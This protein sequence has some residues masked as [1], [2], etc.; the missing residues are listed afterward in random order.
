MA[1]KAVSRADS[2]LGTGAAAL[3][4]GGVFDRSAAAFTPRAAQ[5]EMAQ[6]VE[7]TLV[8]GGV[9]VAESG[10]GTGKTYAYL[11]PIIATG[12]RT[13]ISTATLHLQEQIFNRDLPQ[14]RAALGISVDA[15][16][17][18]G[19]ANY[20]CR[21]R[22]ALRMRQS[23]LPGE[24]QPGDYR[25]LERWAAATKHGDIAEVAELG[26]GSP[27]WREVTSTADNCLGGTCP[28]FDGCFVFKARR[29]AMQANLVVV[30]HHLFFSDMAMQA[31]GGGELLP[32]HDAVIFDEA[33]TLAEIAS[34]FFGFAVS[35]AQ[36]AELAADTAAAEADERSGVKL[37]PVTALLEGAVQG[38]QRV[39]WAA[40]ESQASSLG[41]ASVLPGASRA[42]DFEDLSN[43]EFG[44][45]IDHLRHAM[46]QF[47]LTLATAAPAGDGL[48]RCHERCLQMQ[49]HLDAWHDGGDR[50]LIRWAEIGARWFRLHGTPLS[51]GARFVEMMKRS[52]AWV[53][54]SATLA[55]GD[56]FSAF[57]AAL[58]LGEVE[59]RRWSS[60]YDFRRHAL[61]YL[62]PD[63]PDPRDE[64]YADALTEVLAAVLG[65]S[66]GRAF[67]LFT[68]H[69]MMRRVHQ[70]LSASDLD[71]ALLLQ[72]QAPKAE[73]LRRFREAPRAALFGSA[74]FWEGVDVQGEDLSCV[75]IDKLP[76]AAPGEPVLK[77]RL[78][79]CEEAGDNPFMDIQVPAAVTAL[80]QGAGRLIRSET[81][82]G[83]LV[84]CDPRLL[85][86]GYG[87]LFL[88]SLP[89]MTQ[90]RSMDDVIAFFAASP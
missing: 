5:Q 66:R 81:D 43:A 32:K 31:E 67:C 58:G 4:A 21:H 75:I 10:T 12:K 62:P 82:R 44:R 8:H 2:P 30:N 77:N 20:L 7:D 52:P 47:Q 27:V 80:K 23:E 88:A 90:T 79:A 3:A 9:L 46:E 61:R 49:E 68:S 48:K 50:N 15:A 63:M 1:W 41:G 40:A 71:C 16:L 33:H 59:A 84:L 85:S 18:K 11:A 22:L 37:A 13:I 55:V 86:K 69:A 14:V 35:G 76:F 28:D 60:P 36:F 53:F 17:L 54:T 89:D 72:G 34:I 42:M 74:S 38:V 70:N 65:A 45:A 83:V 51:I 73:L 78:A 39:A 25:L 24:A 57:C 64:G 56:N 26:E 19:R 87:R 29:R 6:A